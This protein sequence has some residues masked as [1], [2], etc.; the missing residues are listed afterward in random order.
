VAQSSTITSII[1]EH[2]DFLEQGC[3][4]ILDKAKAVSEKLL[5][6]QFEF[7]RTLRKSYEAI[8][9]S[10]PAR[11]S[12]SS[13]L[14]LKNNKQYDRALDIQK[15]GCD[16]AMVFAGALRTSE[17]A[18]TM[19]S[20]KFNYLLKGMPTPPRE[21]SQALLKTLEAWENEQPLANCAQFG[22]NLIGKTCCV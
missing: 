14:R 9:V 16:G 15:L 4:P 13:G 3:R 18:H 19:S 11:D 12:E 20:P 5:E 2:E 22:N 6:G 8:Y 17:C 1:K 10:L 21:C 7:G